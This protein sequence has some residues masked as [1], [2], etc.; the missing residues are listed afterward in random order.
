MFEVKVFIVCF[1]IYFM[2]K[3]KVLYLYYL[4]Y[5]VKNFAELV[6]LLFVFESRGNEGV[7]KSDG[8]KFI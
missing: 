6:L 4:I 7:E 1:D 5:F 3:G 8:Y 2:D